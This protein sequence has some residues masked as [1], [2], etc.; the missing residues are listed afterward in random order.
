[1]SGQAQEHL[2][3]PAREVEFA[4]NPDLDE[5]GTSLAWRILTSPRTFLALTGALGLFF[6]L[7]AFLPQRPLPNELARA[8]PF[9][10]AEVARDLGLVDALTAWPTALLLLLLGLNAVGLVLGARER[11]PLASATCELPVAL[12]DAR[13]RAIALLRRGRLEVTG[14]SSLVIRRGLVREGLALA[15]LGALTLLAALAVDRIASREA[16]LTLRPGAPTASETALRDGDTLLLASLPFGLMC[17]RPDPQDPARHF[18]CRLAREGSTPTDVTLLPG[19]RSHLDDLSLTPLRERLDSPEPTSPID[20]VIN[21]EGQRER[22]RLEPGKRVALRGGEHLTALHGSDGPFV[23][24]EPTTGPPTLLLP[25]LSPSAPSALAFSLE[26]EHPTRIDVEVVTAPERPLLFAGLALLVLGLLLAGLVPHAS[27]TLRTRGDVTDI[28][29]SSLNRPQLPATLCALLE[30]QESR[31]P[32]NSILKPFPWVSL[33]GLLLAA[34]GLAL[35]LPAAPTGPA[36]VL[37][38]AALVALPTRATL[39]LGALAL[40]GGLGAHGPSELIA[41]DFL[42]PVGTGLALGLLSRVLARDLDALLRGRHELA[43]ALVALGL[44]LILALPLPH[45]AL[46]AVDGGPLLLPALLGDGATM[47][48]TVWPVPAFVAPGDSLLNDFATV[49]AALSALF[50]LATHFAPATSKALT[51]TNA[52]RLGVLAGALGVA[53]GV[54]GLLSLAAPPALEASQLRAALDLAASR[55]GVVLDVNLPPYALELASRPFLDGLR[56]LAGLGLVATFVVRRRA[57]SEPGAHPLSPAS[58]GALALGTLALFGATFSAGGLAGP[59]LLVLGGLIVMAGG[60]VT[61]ALSARD[62]L[63]PRVS[64]LAGT[65]MLA[66]SPI[67]PLL[68]GA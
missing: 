51:P 65:A 37:G 48:R 43:G 41:V 5:P 21:R 53:V 58:Y 56:I 55:D 34:A 26:A 60:L 13:T 46:A 6:A 24:V 28:I 16:R 11:A 3:R 40:I 64:L 50:L 25:A 9:A 7:A 22:L 29:A 57:P 19:H 17:D 67:L 2:E 59:G 35:G 8:L 10:S 12:D 32:S 14:P 18:P 45:V 39:P 62:K 4:T 30:N 1:M 61:A 20:L 23:I 33:G 36:L 52:A 15:T 54:A 38:L 49:L 42:L 27:L 44:G 63:A 31:N 66:L 68:Y 47:I